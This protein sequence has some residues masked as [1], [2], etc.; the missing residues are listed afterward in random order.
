[1]AHPGFAAHQEDGLL[2]LAHGLEFACLVD[3]VDAGGGAVAG[4]LG[5]PDGEDDQ[6]DDGRGDDG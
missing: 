6:V 4:A 2:H 5:E 3:Q 1:M